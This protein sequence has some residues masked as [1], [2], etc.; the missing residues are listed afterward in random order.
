MLGIILLSWM[1]LMGYVIHA[2]GAAL[3]F[4]HLN[5]TQDGSASPRRF[6]A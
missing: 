3:V 1:S 4:E 5:P 6:P 2:I